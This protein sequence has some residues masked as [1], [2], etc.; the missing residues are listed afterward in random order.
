LVNVSIQLEVHI[1]KCN[2]SMKELHSLLTDIHVR[3]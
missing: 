1:R 2:A 3:T